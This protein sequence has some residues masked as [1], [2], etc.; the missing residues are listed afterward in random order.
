MD[1]KKI[2][3]IAGMPCSGKSTLLRHSL[4]NGISLF[5][6]SNDSVFKL[7]RIP[8]FKTENANKFE[9]RLKNRFWLHELDLIYSKINYIELNSGVIHFDLYCYFISV[10][11]AK[12]KIRHQDINNL[13]IIK[14]IIANEDNLFKIFETV[15][16]CIPCNTEVALV[17]LNTKYDQLCDRW[18]GRIGDSRAYNNNQ[19][20]LHRYIYDSSSEGERICES[21]INSSRKAFDFAIHNA[22][23]DPAL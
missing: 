1:S 6:E 22:V 4:I 2:L 9:T 3:I 15:K 20:F 17:M 7:T 12:L 14:R 13:Q 10:L 11:M 21:F 18:V 23:H 8:Y 19:E 5:G 16:N